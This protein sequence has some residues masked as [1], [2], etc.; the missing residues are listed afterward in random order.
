MGGVGKLAKTIS[1]S[2]ATA[3]GEPT[4]FAPSASSGRMAA[5]LLSKIVRLLPAS[6]KRRHIGPPIRPTPTKPT[7][8]KAIEYF[9]L[10]QSR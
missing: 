4:R 10:H 9:S 6:I 8:R 3:A 7:F 2:E 5:S 1:A